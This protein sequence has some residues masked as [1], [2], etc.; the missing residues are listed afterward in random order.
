MGRWVVRATALTLRADARHRARAVS[1]TR[2]GAILHT[3]LTQDWADEPNRVGYDDPA[4]PQPAAVSSAWLRV[5]AVDER[6]IGGALRELAAPL[7]AAREWCEEVRDE[8]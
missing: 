5:V 8:P 7:F 6:P 3:N 2:A 1:R 4:T